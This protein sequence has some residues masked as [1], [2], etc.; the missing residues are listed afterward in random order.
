MKNFLILISAVLVLA[1][2]SVAVAGV[3]VEDFEDGV[4]D[5]IWFT[6]G[7]YTVSDGVL[8][9]YGGYDPDPNDEN[10]GFYSDV[11]FVNPNNEFVYRMEADI[12][13]SS[14]QNQMVGLTYNFREP[15]P[16]Y[17]EQQIGLDLSV[18]DGAA[19]F[20][21]YL[22]IMSDEYA[23]YEEF[24]G[25]GTTD[26]WHHLSLTIHDNSVTISVDGNETIL[27]EGLIQNPEHYNQYVSYIHGWA[28]LLSNA[29][30]Y[31]D[32]IAVHTAGGATISDTLGSFDAW[33]ESG[34]LAGAGSGSFLPQIRLSLMRVMLTAAGELIE[35]D[36]TNL[37]CITLERA[38]LRSD[39]AAGRPTSLRER[40]S[41]N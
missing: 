3:Y 9:M 14:G 5:A 23:Q 37:A 16:A 22:A 19:E 28:E 20:R 29:D 12:K 34:E 30:Y 35:R 2:A 39:G 10:Y 24:I 1:G 6:H 32:N 4:L 15:E 21:A 38:R 27:F 26:E 40:R 8:H 11:G 17:V 13:V 41:G 25:L 36:R 7:D 18:T 31:V 33:V